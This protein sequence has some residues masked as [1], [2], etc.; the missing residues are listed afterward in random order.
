M[1]SRSL[2]TPPEKVS[3]ELIRRFA[4]TLTYEMHWFTYQMLADFLDREPENSFCN[5][6][7]QGMIDLDC[8]IS[9]GRGVYNIVGMDLPK[10]IDVETN[11]PSQ[12]RS[13][14][15]ISDFRD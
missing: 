14:R 1:I 4:D 15:L 7:A 11:Y 10:R 6:V 8:V 5:I 3:E 13:H 9:H 12:T 2:N